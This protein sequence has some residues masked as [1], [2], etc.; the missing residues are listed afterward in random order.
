MWPER[1]ARSTCSLR[2]LLWAWQRSRF[3]LVSPPEL[4]ALTADGCVFRFGRRAAEEAVFPSEAPGRCA[5]LPG[6]LD[7]ALAIAAR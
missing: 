4:S 6:A 1:R 5:W 2:F 3:G 7:L